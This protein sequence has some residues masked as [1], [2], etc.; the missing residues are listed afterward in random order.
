[1]NIR[2]RIQRLEEKA[3]AV[4]DER[5]RI[6]FEQAALEA[7]VAPGVFMAVYEGVRA[8]KLAS[9]EDWP[10]LEGTIV[11]AL[12]RRGLPGATIRR[13]LAQPSVLRE[14]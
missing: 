4:D 9:E 1:M 7:G 10:E 11:R 5:D 3:V 13:L 14:E 8:T 12:K 6:R 2:R